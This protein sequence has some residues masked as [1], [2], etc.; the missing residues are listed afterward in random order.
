MT[1][2]PDRRI[3]GLNVMDPDE[4][5]CVVVG[6]GNGVKS[7]KGDKGVKAGK[8]TTFGMRYCSSH[9]CFLSILNHVTM[10]SKSL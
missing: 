6:N 2:N 10:A 3:E 7:R 4:A 9:V 1:N 8:L 5:L